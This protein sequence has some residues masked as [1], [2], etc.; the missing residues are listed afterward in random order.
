MNI[1][2]LD[3]FGHSLVAE[4]IFLALEPVKQLLLASNGVPYYPKLSLMTPF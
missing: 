1:M 2:H 3:A 4:Y